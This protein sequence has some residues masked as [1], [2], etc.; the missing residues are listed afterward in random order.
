MAQ[1]WKKWLRWIERKVGRI[2]EAE[3]DDTDDERM[4]LVDDVSDKVVL[5]RPTWLYGI[6]MRSGAVLCALGSGL[7]LLWLAAAD[8]VVGGGAL[9]FELAIRASR[10]RESR[11]REPVQ[12]SR[13]L[14]WRV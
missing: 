9:P 1:N 14:T 10:R 4:D 5:R 7:V 11:A 3:D 2:D 8:D 6:R 13:W 12:A